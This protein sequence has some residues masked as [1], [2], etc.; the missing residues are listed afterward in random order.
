M[1]KVDR[2]IFHPH[3][4]SDDT[5]FFEHVV[6]PFYMFL[7]MES[8]ELAENLSLSDPSVQHFFN[9]ILHQDPPVRMPG[10]SIRLD[11][12]RPSATF[13][14]SSAQRGRAFVNNGERGPAGLTSAPTCH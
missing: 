7:R 6:E 14:C 4:H 5:M 9:L 13:Q 3:N 8:C 10:D 1:L 11:L 2:C 12:Q